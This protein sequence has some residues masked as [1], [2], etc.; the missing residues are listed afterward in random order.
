MTTDEKLPLIILL[1]A[2]SCFLIKADREITF[3]GNLES[4]LNITQFVKLINAIFRNVTKDT[5]FLKP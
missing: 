3:A 1:F 5:F 4:F 2:H